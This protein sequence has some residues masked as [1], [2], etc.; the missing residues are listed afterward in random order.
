MDFNPLKLPAPEPSELF[1]VSQIIEAFCNECNNKEPQK[2]YFDTVNPPYAINIAT[3]LSGS[4]EPV[5]SEG[6]WTKEN[7]LRYKKSLGKWIEFYSGQWA[8]Y[9]EELYLSRVANNLSNR[10]SEVHFIR[11]N[12]SFIFMPSS[13]FEKFMPYMNEYFFEQILKV[14]A[15][16]FCY[17]ILNEEI[18]NINDIFPELREKPLKEIEKEIERVGDL[19]RLV[20]KLAS[21]VFAE[22]IVN[23]RA[24]SR[25]VLQTCYN[26]FQIELT[27]TT[28][29]N[30]IK[31]LEQTLASERAE[32]QQKLAAQ[33][34]RWILV[35][36]VLLGGQI[37]FTL[38]DQ[39]ITYFSLEGTPVEELISTGLL[40]LV[41]LIVVVA[42]SGLAYTWLSK[43]IDFGR[44]LQ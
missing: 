31:N 44:L 34:K 41:G 26:L 36:N 17:Y 28:L 27:S 15:I 32:N 3:K 21:R 18:D 5:S 37:V 42:V 16:L 14:R 33:Q 19:N 38:R 6:I 23:R 7:I 40:A 22:R 43:R 11:T 9:S 12:S 29:T 8:D 24:H 30:K 20:Q 35:L 39:L 25:K 13:G 10:L 1:K 2:I 4:E